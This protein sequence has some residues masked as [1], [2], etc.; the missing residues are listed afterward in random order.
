MS[1]YKYI[2]YDMREINVNSTETML[3]FFL[4]FMTI[5][6]CSYM[7]KIPCVEFLGWYIKK[8]VKNQD[9]SISISASGDRICLL[10]MPI[11]YVFE[12][13]RECI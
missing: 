13:C 10:C 1:L 2:C 4:R 6:D 8:N 9:L 7:F 12:I 11:I 3:L 5:T